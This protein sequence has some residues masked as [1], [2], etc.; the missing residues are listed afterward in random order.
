VDPATFAFDTATAL[1]SA[2]TLLFSSLD[3]RRRRTAENLDLRA[4]LWQ[5]SRAIHRWELDAAVTDRTFKKWLEGALDDYESTRA[6]DYRTAVQNDTADAT[7]AL[8]LGKDEYKIDRSETRAGPSQP[9]TWASRVSYII[10][11]PNKII[12]RQDWPSLRNLL[13]IYSPELLEIL[14][15]AFGQ[16]RSMI[17]ELI[18]QFPYL[19]AQGGE[20]AQAVSAHLQLAA[21]EL[22]KASK[23]LDDY[24]R[25]SFPA[26]G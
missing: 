5:L 10:G 13:Q 25:E 18:D 26:G 22:G 23:L 12:A 11:R 7:Y 3:A 1:T 16:R 6:L 2:L 19:R 24:I 20:E 21:T 14:L 9:R 17:N 15:T 8:L 4:G